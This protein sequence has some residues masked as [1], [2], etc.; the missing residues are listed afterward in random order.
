MGTN[1]RG[2]KKHRKARAKRA[3]YL[4]GSKRNDEG[5]LMFKTLL[6]VIATC[7]ILSIG[8]ASAPPSIGEEICAAACENIGGKYYHQFDHTCYCKFE[9]P[10]FRPSTKQDTPSNMQD[11]PKKPDISPSGGTMVQR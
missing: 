2:I 4:H 1:T 8:C 3:S 5:D 9:M 7:V 10:H 6:F 11:A